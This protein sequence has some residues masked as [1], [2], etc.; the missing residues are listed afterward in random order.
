MRADV[1]AAVRPDRAQPTPLQR[2]GEWTLHLPFQ[3]VSEVPSLNDRDHWAVKAKKVKAW[4][5]A[6][7]L[8]ARHS[9]V[10]ACRRVRVELHYIPATNQRRDPDNLVAAYKP[11]VDGLV[12]AG[13]VLDDTESY[14]ERV[15]PVIH[16]AQKV[17]PTRVDTRFA[18][19]IVAL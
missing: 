2:A 3:V 18:L 4:R 11:L 19:R 8:L 5:D 1:P 10:P 13:V 6:A 12:D 17:L 7:H 14:V 15:F 16:P 9:R